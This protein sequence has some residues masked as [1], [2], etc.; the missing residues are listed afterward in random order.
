MDYNYHTHT[1][2]CGHATGSDEEYVKCAMEAGIKYLGFSDHTSFI[3]PDGHEDNWRV[4]LSEAENYVKS[5]NSLREKYREKVEI[6]V[7]FEMEYYSEYFDQ[8]LNIAR[9]Y[10]AEYL[11]LAQHFIHSQYPNGVGSVGPTDSEEHLS[12]YVDEVI[13]GM[14]TGFFSYV[15]HPDL[16]CFTGDDEVYR[17][18]ITRLCMA[19]KELN[20]PLEINLLGIR[21]NKHYPD[22]KFWQIVGEIGA[23]VTIGYDAHASENFLDTDQLDKANELIKKFNLN[24]I[25]KPFIRLIK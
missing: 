2:R 21:Y 15:A 23:P 8:M 19:S 17:K 9:K 10:G 5:I 7:G 24:Y 3:F 12:C 22:E 20:I 11:I 1:S 14:K 16:V 13:Q 18:H 4:P 25:G 6:I